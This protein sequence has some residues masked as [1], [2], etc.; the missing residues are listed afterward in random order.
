MYL[1][2]KHSIFVL[3]SYF[4]YSFF[5]ILF[6]E[7][8]CFSYIVLSK[9]F[10]FLFV[11]LL[12]LFYEFYLQFDQKFRKLQISMIQITYFECPKVFEGA[13]SIYIFK[14]VI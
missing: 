14:N 12:S 4:N 10:I 11:Q 13:E 3:L 1:L 5:N 9:Q 2:C 8:A 6:N 7:Y